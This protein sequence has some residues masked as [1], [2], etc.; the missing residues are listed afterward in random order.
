VQLCYF[1]LVLIAQRKIS[2]LTFN[3]SN[4]SSNLRKQAP[5]FTELRLLQATNKRCGKTLLFPHA[6][7]NTA[8]IPLLGNLYLDWEFQQ[9]LGKNLGN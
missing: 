9:R 2:I 3:E 5:L 8:G 7:D 4:T 1:R 6:L